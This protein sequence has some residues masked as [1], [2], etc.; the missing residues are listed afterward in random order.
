MSNEIYNLIEHELYTLNSIADGIIATTTDGKIAFSNHSACSILGYSQSEMI[1]KHLDKFFILKDITNNQIIST[2]VSEVVETGRQAG[3]NKNSVL[4]SQDKS[5][6]YISASFAPLSFESQKDVGV[7]VVFRDITRIR[8]MEKSIEAEKTKFSTIF[9]FA[10]VGLI[11]LEKN[12]RIV[13]VNEYVTNLFHLKKED[14]YHTHVGAALKCIHLQKNSCGLSSEC[15]KCPL[16]L[17]KL[18]ILENFDNLL[19]IEVPFKQKKDSG[20]IYELWLKINFSNFKI[21]GASHILMVIEDVSEKNHILQELRNAKEHAVSANHAKSEFLA[22]M[23]HEIRTPLNGITGMIDLTLMSDIPKEQ[24]E[25]LEVAKSCVDTLLIVINDILDFSKIEAGKMEIEHY[26]FD[27]H[28]LL[29]KNIKAFTVKCSEKGVDLIPELSSNIPQN[30]VGDPIR[31]N[32]ILNNLLSNA[33][34]FTDIGTIKLKVEAVETTNEIAHI[35]FQVIDTGTGIKEKDISKLFKSFS[36]ADSS[37]T[38]KYAGTGLGL[39]ISKSLTEKMNGF[40]AVTSEYG[41]GST[42]QFTLP[43]ELSSANTPTVQPTD[44]HLISSKSL[45]ILLVED[46][47]VNQTV[48]KLILQDMGHKLTISC[49]G[50]KAY[51]EIQVNIYD[52][53]IMDI[54]M[55]VMDGIT[56]TKL[57]RQYQFEN[58]YYTPI[59]ALT[60]H[61]IVGDKE[62]FLSTGMDFYISKPINA[63]ELFETLEQIIEKLVN[64]DFS[65][66]KSLSSS[67][68]NNDELLN[69]TINTKAD[70]LEELKIYN[71]NLQSAIRQSDYQSAEKYSHIIKALSEKINDTALKQIA[72]RIELASRKKNFEKIQKLL[73]QIQEVVDTITK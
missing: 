3:L 47:L 60:A 25:N 31:I 17:N 26:S 54:Q 38:K 70:A 61:A 71:Y 37:Y 57:I 21:N 56:A 12:F 58:N 11:I 19:N 63:P 30:V 9:N 69:E 28:N 55:P 40:I 7:I 51:D 33:Y 42:F 16:A 2:P 72:F 44:T 52:L 49:D 46:D 1:H 27:L 10:P 14:I 45:N 13:D 34:K 18:K 24:K 64:G 67:D 6:K 22:N 43:L 4:I 5:I 29:A 41:K 65:N 32:Q 62:K 53:I 48:I 39:T 35:N 66:K 36:Q 20:V 23:S 73:I 15:S 59:M 8:T 50:Q 68:L